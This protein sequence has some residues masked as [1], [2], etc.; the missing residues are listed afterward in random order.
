MKAI[1]NEKERELYSLC[2]IALDNGAE[3]A[4][5]IPASDV[6]I[7]E[8]VSMKCLVPICSF[9]GR[10]IMCPPNLI[11]VEHFKRIASLYSAAILIQIPSSS[12]PAPPEVASAVSLDDVW[13]T[14][15]PTNRVDHMKSTPTIE[16]FNEL[17]ASQEKLYSIINAIES[18]SLKAGNRFSIGFA[19]GGCLLC[20]KCVGPDSSEPCNHPFKARPSME[21]M[22]IDVVGTAEKAGIII[23]FLGTQ[24]SNWFGLIFID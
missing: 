21:A 8:R 1:A 12:R 20:E 23:D 15:N 14:M 13:K 3:K 4:V 24:S 19:A 16:Y 22:G 18:A 6:V 11:S 2:Q 10:N 9:Y 17:K 5:P 7:D